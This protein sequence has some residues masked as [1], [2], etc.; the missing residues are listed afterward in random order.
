METMIS[1]AEK[2]GCSIIAAQLNSYAMSI[3][4]SNYVRDRRSDLPL[5]LPLT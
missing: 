2:I 1:F 5:E 4:G 3:P